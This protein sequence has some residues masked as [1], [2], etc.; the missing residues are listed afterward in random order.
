VLDRQVVGGVWLD[1]AALLI[2]GVESDTPVTLKCFREP[3]DAALSRVTSRGQ[4]L[5]MNVFT[6]RDE[7]SGRD[8]QALLPIATAD[9][10]APTF[11]MH[12]ALPVFE[13]WGRQPASRDLEEPRNIDEQWDRLMRHIRETIEPAS[14]KPRYEQS[15]SMRPIGAWLLVKQ[16]ART[17]RAIA[18]LLTEMAKHP[19]ER[20]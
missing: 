1:G 14:W 19:E 8:H 18:Q 16:P 7:V 6:L 11:V 3:R 5:P 9:A 10:I 13:A 2:S 12:D 15:T 20:Q 17:Q 4:P